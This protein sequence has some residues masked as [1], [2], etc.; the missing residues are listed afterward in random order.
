LPRYQGGRGKINPQHHARTPGARQGI[1]AMLPNSQAVPPESFPP[2][3]RASLSS[4][5]EDFRRVGVL[6]LVCLPLVLYSKR[7]GAARI[8][9]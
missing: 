1:G 2:Q 8:S 6:C 4:L 7:R 5:P 9:F 3:K